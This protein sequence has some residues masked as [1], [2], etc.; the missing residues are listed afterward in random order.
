MRNHSEWNEESGIPCKRCVFHTAYL[1]H[2]NSKGE[3]RGRRRY[4]RDS[5]IVVSNLKG[6]NVGTNGKKSQTRPNYREGPNYKALRGT[7]VPLPQIK[8]TN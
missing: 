1:M 8:L 4:K 7:R 6:R 2:L 3:A 5:K